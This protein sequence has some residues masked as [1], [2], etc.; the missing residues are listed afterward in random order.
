MTNCIIK[1]TPIKKRTIPHIN[2]ETGDRDQTTSQWCLQVLA[3]AF[4]Q[5]EDLTSL[6]KIQSNNQFHGYIIFWL[7][8]LFVGKHGEFIENR[9]ETPVVGH[10]NLS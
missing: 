8:V 9:L 2:E 7:D 4:H 5:E 3:S 6:T 1:T 10:G